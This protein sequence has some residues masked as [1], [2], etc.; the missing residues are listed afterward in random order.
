MFV[1]WAVAIVWY[2]YG[3]ADN[4][5]TCQMTTDKYLLRA[6][7]IAKLDGVIKRISSIQMP[8]ELTSHWVT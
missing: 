4:I 7:E 1:F 2:L 8:S 6:D 5:G 3:T